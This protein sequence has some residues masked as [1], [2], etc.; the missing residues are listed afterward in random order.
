MAS[1]VAEAAWTQ[2]EDTTQHSYW[3][4]Q[5]FCLLKCLLS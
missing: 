2:A 4:M 5:A 3:Q 1:G